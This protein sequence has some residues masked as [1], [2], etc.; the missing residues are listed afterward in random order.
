MPGPTVQSLAGLRLAVGVGAWL[1]PNL[2]GR[3]FGLDPA[4]NPQSV[5]MARLFGIRDVAL[6]VGAL[7]AAPEA[8]RLWLQLGLLSDVADVGAAGLA[9]RDGSVSG[10]VAAVLGGV[11]VA[12]AASGI[13]VLSQT[14]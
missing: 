5:Y 1:A 3:M 12:A 8:R 10:P 4:S 9:R 11:A 13:A 6:G 2:T 14:E 7:S